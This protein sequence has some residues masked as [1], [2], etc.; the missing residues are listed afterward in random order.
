LGTPLCAG[1]RVCSSRSLE[2]QDQGAAVSRPPT[3][4][5]RRFRNR[6]SLFGRHRHFGV[7]EDQF[8]TS[9]QNGLRDG[10][11]GSC[12]GLFGAASRGTGKEHQ[13]EVAKLE[14]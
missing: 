5:K 7:S 8:L 12:G 6:R 10:F 2:R 3:N 11:R 9:I 4:Q 1:M 13:F 14:S